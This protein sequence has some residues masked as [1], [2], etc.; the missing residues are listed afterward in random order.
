MAK[1]DEM[2][3][4]QPP[5]LAIARVPDRLTLEL[6]TALCALVASGE[7]VSVA[8]G[9]LGIS[10]ETIRVWCKRALEPGAPAELVAFELAFMSARRV[11]LGVYTARM[12]ASDD[13]KAA[14]WVAERLDPD[15]EARAPALRTEV[16]GADGG[17][18]E[19]A[20]VAAE[21]RAAVARL[22]REGKP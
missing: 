13:W 8:C 20:Q 3:P 21:V 1:T 12:K 17:A 18:I 14:A 19:I 15:G 7:W 22:G 6:Q 10:R 2:L 11:G 9:K 16:T 5:D 4:V